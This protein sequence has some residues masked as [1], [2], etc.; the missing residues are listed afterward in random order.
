MTLSIED[1]V[2][3]V[4][5]SPDTK[6]V[7]A[8][9]LD[10]SVRVWDIHQGFL[11]ERL[12]GPDG[13][14]D[15]VYSVA[16]SPNGKDLVSGSLDK[17]IKMWELASPRG[18][19]QNPGPK[20][21]RCVKTFEGHRVCFGLHLFA[22]VLCW[23]VTNLWENRISFYPWLSLLMPTGLCLVPRT[24]ASSSGIPEPATL[25]LCCRD[26]RTR[27]SPWHP[28]PAEPISRLGQVT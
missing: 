2:T 6:Y 8:G 13:H 16:F 20:A 23:I 15:S 11:L 5:I 18:G 3:T 14:K 22:I 25:S 28:A 27:S 1:G 26:T 24:G 17:T 4:A 19:M 7:A 10:K 21:G 9:S 12:E